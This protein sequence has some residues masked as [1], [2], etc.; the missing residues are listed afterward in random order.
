[1]S[2][3]SSAA[4]GARCRE[5]RCWREELERPNERC[6]SRGE[7]ASGVRWVAPAWRACASCCPSAL[8]LAADIGPWARCWLAVDGDT[9]PSLVWCAPGRL[10]AAS[11]SSRAS[12]AP[13]NVS[14]SAAA[15]AGAGAG[16]A[17]AEE[18]TGLPLS[19][20]ATS[21]ASL[22]RN[23]AR[24]ATAAATTVLVAGWA[25]CAGRNRAA[26]GGGRDRFRATCWSST[27]A[28]TGLPTKSRAPALMHRAHRARSVWLD[29]ITTRVRLS[30]SRSER[31][32]SISRPVIPSGME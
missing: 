21:P 10:A 18:E 12:L 4:P 1:M 3:S 6:A 30:K 26:G 17:E 7:G 11:P 5:A 8:V 16:K 19:P 14:P 27:G 22:W 24:A 28:V 2:T 32:L 15:G 31:Q 13:A 25:R 29:S 9:A 20:R 23:C